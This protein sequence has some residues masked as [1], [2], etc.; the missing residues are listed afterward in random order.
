[1][2]PLL[3]V[4]IA[5]TRPGRAGL[6]IVR[7]FIERAR[8][9]GGFEIDIADLSEIDLLFLDEPNHPRLRRY[10]RPH[11][12]DWSARVGGAAAFAF[13]TSEYNYGYPAP[14]KNAL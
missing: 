12:L 2:M 13:V 11:T 8:L 9:H 10:T 4:V 1:A 3:S 5:S 6:P 14:L 7:W